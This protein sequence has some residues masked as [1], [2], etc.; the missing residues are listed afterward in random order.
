LLK[1]IKQYKREEE[2]RKREL[3]E[4]QDV[5]KE[6]RK[7]NRGIRDEMRREM[8]KIRGSID[9][10]STYGN[11]SRRYLPTMTLRSHDDPEVRGSSPERSQDGEVLAAAGAP[12]ES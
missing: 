10:E 8:Q 6:L 1:E 3:S 7:E 4:L 2:K 5:I 11:E 9:R 12:R